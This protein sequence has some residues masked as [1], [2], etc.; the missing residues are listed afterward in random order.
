GI[1]AIGWPRDQAVDFLLAHTAMDRLTA[2]TETD[3]YIAQP[4]QATSYMIGRLEIQRLRDEAERRLGAQFSIKQFHDVVLSNGMT[5]LGQLA[6]NV[7]VW[8]ERQT[9]NA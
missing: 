2:E 3:R 7:D 1:H 4:G 8:I 6:R 9:A 5:P